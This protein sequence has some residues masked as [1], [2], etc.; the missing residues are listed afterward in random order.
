[1]GAKPFIF[2]CG[3]D[4][5]LVNRLGKE[6]YDALAADVSDEFSREV[7]NGLANN[8]GEVEIAVNRFREA[9]QTMSL[10]GGKRV[11]WFK[12]V[13]FLADSVTGRAEGTL[14]LVEDLQALLATVNPEQVSVLITAAPV[15]RRRAFIKWCEASADYTFIGDDGAAGGGMLE[16]VALTEVAAQGVTMT[17]DALGLLLAK[18]GT[19]TRLLVEEVHKLS[20]Y[21]SEG[22]MIEE[23][24][25][26]ELT[27]NFAEGDFFEA[28]D[29]FGRG[30]LPRT[31][32]ALRRHF[33][34]GGDARPVI[35]ALQ[36]RNRLLVQLRVLMDAGEIRL[37]PRGFDK[38]GFDRAAAAHS[39]SFAGAAEKSSFNVFTQNPW[40]LGKLAGSAKLP[41]LRR[42]IDNQQ[43][44]IAAFEEL[45]RRP[46][47]Q[48]EVLHEM[49]VRCLT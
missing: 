44:F 49:A 47:E 22:G 19:N 34:A 4:D 13:S 16:E 38:A 3:P 43:E 36:N 7:L 10:F 1:M 39:A 2:I 48:E 28:A 6:R 41:A 27:P 5:F 32:A 8:M 24:H 40:Y 18:I 33:F 42:L 46:S 26:E 45:I 37:G 30:D 29:A 23:R 14:R 11:V 12:D 9:V 35:T 20:N 31:L 21:V 17:P 25:V 15:D